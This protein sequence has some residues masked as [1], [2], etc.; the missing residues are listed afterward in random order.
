[1]GYLIVSIIVA[2]ATAISIY[3]ASQSLLLAF[4]ASSAAGTM[5]LVSALVA[6]SLV[7]GDVRD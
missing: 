4:L 2:M 5:T 6:D 3:V 7:K 1:M